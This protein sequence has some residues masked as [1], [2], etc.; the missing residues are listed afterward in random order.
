MS[1]L[2][3]I[4]FRCP[5]CGVSLNAKGAIAG[6]ES[7]CPKCKKRL[8]VPESESAPARKVES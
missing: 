7:N 5:H 2:S 1:D 8:V 4:I 6:R 3:H